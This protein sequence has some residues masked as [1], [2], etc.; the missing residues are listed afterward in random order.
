M[1][2]DK[3]GCERRGQ[4]LDQHRFRSLGKLVVCNLDWIADVHDVGD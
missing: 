1:T 4:R 3:R 2:T